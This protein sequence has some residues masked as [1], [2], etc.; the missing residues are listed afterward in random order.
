MFDSRV[1]HSFFMFS[2]DVE[3]EDCHDHHVNQ[4][5]RI[6]FRATCKN[7]GSAILE[8]HWRVWVIEDGKF[9]RHFGKFTVFCESKYL[10][11]SI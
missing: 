3:C 1:T 4:Q 6:E 7:C 8:Y 10:V 9:R 5:D 2:V 11:F